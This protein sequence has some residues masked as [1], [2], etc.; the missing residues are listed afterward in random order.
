MAI[1]GVKI[2]GLILHHDDRGFFSE[3][4]RL[5][6]DVGLTKFSQWS[7]SKAH[8]GVIKSGHLHKKQTDWMC[9]IDGD[10]ELTLNDLREPSKTYKTEIKIGMGSRLG[11]KVVK[12][13]PGVAHGYRVLSP[14]MLIVYL[15]DQEYDPK[16][17]F[18]IGRV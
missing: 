10:I 18:R 7:F 9:V 11:Y 8:E 3:I 13:P 15:T 17:E 4:L 12:I 5:S 1:E 14:S 2:K 6:E 16:D